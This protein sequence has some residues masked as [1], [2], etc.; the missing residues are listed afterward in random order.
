MVEHQVAWC[1][2]LPA[3]PPA[4]GRRPIS[5]SSPAG[6]KQRVCKAACHAGVTIISGSDG[7]TF[8]HGDNATEIERWLRRMPPEARKAATSAAW[9]RAAHGHASASRRRYGSP[10]CAAVTDPLK[11]IGALRRVKFVMKGG[12]VYKFD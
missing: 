1:P 6:A 2:T 3:M 4:S 7:G 8:T 11:E 10:I 5:R 12:T 9:T